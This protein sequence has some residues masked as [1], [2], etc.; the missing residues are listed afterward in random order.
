MNFPNF[1]IESKRIDQLQKRNQGEKG[2]PQRPGTAAANLNRHRGLQKTL[3]SNTT[4][5]EQK[6]KKYVNRL[7]KMKDQGSTMIKEANE[8]AEEEP[9][10]LNTNQIQEDA[11]YEVLKQE[12]ESVRAENKELRHLLRL[13]QQK[14]EEI[15]R[16][17]FSLEIDNKVLKAQASS[18][19]ILMKDNLELKAKLRVFEEKAEDE[20]NVE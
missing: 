11:G 8:E 9:F 10:N 20:E 1:F 7:E 12:F 18:A 3:K 15:T 2:E 19:D 14:N 17:K 6:T 13:E 16:K 5:Q 4:T